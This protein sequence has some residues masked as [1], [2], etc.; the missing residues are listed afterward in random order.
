[1]KRKLWIALFFALLLTAV[2][3]GAYAADEHSFIKQ[4]TVS[5]LNGT[6]RTFTISWKTSF[7]PLK[8]ELVYKLTDSWNSYLYQ[9]EKTGTLHANETW[10]LPAAYA[11]SIRY[12]IRAYYGDSSTYS[13]ESEDFFISRDSYSTDLPDSHILL[14]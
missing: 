13:I 7:T 9:D 2:C 6:D 1:M 12:R 11:S 5:T 14:L 4:P 3:C 8:I 10:N